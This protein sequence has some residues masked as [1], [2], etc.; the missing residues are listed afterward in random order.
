L[1]KVPLDK[2]VAA[3][4]SSRYSWFPVVDGTF[5]KDLPSKLLNAGKVSRVPLLLG[6][7]IIITLIMFTVLTSF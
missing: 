4:N 2:F 1:R 5:L 3:T 7:M 6:G